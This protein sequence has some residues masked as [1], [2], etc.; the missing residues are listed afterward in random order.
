WVGDCAPVGFVADDG[1]IGVA[2]AGW[3]GAYDGVLQAAVAQLGPT[4]V[5]AYLGPCIH[6]CCYE[7]GAADLQMFV[8]RFGSQVAGSTAWGAAA[9]DMRAVVASALAEVGVEMV[10]VSRCTGCFAEHYYSHRRRRQAGRHVMTICKRA[11]R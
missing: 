2:H 8:G 6:P 3:R 9:L 4:R 1:T 11:Q 5:R 10:D 7:F